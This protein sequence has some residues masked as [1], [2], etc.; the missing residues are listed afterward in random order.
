MS[1]PG[2]GSGSLKHPGHYAHDLEPSV[3]KLFLVSLF[4]F[5]GLEH[6]LTM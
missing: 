2:G 4:S 5:P 3:S 1:G 6:P